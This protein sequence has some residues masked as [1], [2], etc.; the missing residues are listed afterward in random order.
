MFAISTIISKQFALL[1]S[2]QYPNSI[3][4]KVPRHFTRPSYQNRMQ[5]FANNQRCNPNLRNKL[6][7][8]DSGS[9]EHILIERNCKLTL[10]SIKTNIIDFFEY[11]TENVTMLAKQFLTLYT[12]AQNGNQKKRD[13]TLLRNNESLS[14]V[15]LEGTLYNAAQEWTLESQIAAEF[16]ADSFNT[17]YTIFASARKLSSVAQNFV[18]HCSHIHLSIAV[19]PQKFPGFCV[20]IVGTRSVTGRL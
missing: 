6:F 12:N 10:Q 1:P 5:G 14:H 17:H 13:T 16:S 9:P 7:F 8:W 3:R 15:H 4:T 2:K 18:Y 20:D 19:H 11:G